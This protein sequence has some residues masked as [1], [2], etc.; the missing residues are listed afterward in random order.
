M[1]NTCAGKYAAAAARRGAGFV[2]G[3][4]LSKLRDMSPTAANTSGARGVYQERKTGHWRA[5]IVFRQKIISLGSYKTFEEAV[6]ARKEG[7]RRYFG[8]ALAAAGL[9]PKENA[10][11]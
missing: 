11:D 2:G 3:T 7:E 9:S 10:F 8:A 5:R 6:A 1:C 4:Q